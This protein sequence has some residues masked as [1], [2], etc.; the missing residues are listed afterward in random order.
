[1]EK[2]IDITDWQTRRL[3]IAEVAR[4]VGVS[5]PTVWRWVKEG[6]LPQPHKLG[7]NCT[8]WNGQEIAEAIFNQATLPYKPNPKAKAKQVGA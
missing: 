5:R 6:K 3:T 7:M 1:M 2:Q 8:R 4:V